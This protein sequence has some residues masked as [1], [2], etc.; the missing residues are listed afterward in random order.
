VT[1][2][3]ASKELR[4]DGSRLWESLM[5]MAEIGATPE[6][7]SHRL[8]LTD[9]DNAALE[10]FEGWA[11]AEDCR[12]SRD[13][14]GNCFAERPGI[15]PSRP[16]VLVGSHLDTQPGGGRF[17]GPLGTLAALEIVRTLNEHD[18][19]TSAPVIAVSWANEEGARFSLPCT[20]SS[21]FAGVLDF[22]QAMSQR[23]YDGPTFADELERL[24][25]AGTEDLEGREFAA[26]FELHIEQGPVL[27]SANK[28]IGVVSRGQGVRSLR[29]TFTGR[30]SHTGTTPMDVRRD[31]LVGAAR[32]VTAVRELALRSPGAVG[33]VSRLEVTPG[34][35]AVIPGRAELVVDIRHPERDTLDALEAELRREIASTATAAGLDATA[36]T[37]LDIT[38]VVFDR[39]CVRAVEDAAEGLGYPAMEI[40]SGAGHDAFG[41][42]SRMPTA[43]VFI[44]C[45]D[46]VSHHP[47][48][49]AEPEHVR[50]GA[51]VLLRAVLSKAGI[52]GPEG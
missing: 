42:S 29:V 16:P 1:A 6:G 19:R 2:S 37:F 39:S 44:P 48:E 46:G 11:R 35:R 36:E 24:G 45:R 10:L 12:V 8:A 31:A 27:E 34:S 26:Y 13:R 14:M 4:T 20:G 40:V 49:Y 52:V 41:I 17:D 21:V 9:E 23:A 47:A 30:D 15:D 28:V 51:D 18:V 32:L 22:E 3:G 38:P 25:R 33:T 43:M 5:Q 7:G 50:A